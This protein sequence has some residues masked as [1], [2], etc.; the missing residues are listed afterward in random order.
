MALGANVKLALADPGRMS[1]MAAF[2][3]SITPGKYV[4]GYRVT[5]FET[6]SLPGAGSLS[7]EA[8]TKY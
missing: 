8:Q 7:T 6:F 5:C 1:T 2:P 4:T 3:G